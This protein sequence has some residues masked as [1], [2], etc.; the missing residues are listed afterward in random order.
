MRFVIPKG[1]LLCS[2]QYQPSQFDVAILCIP[3]PIIWTIQFSPHNRIGMTA[4]F[5]ATCTVTVILS[6]APTLIIK[7]TESRYHI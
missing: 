3:I 5:L 1:L 7:R 6:Y 2:G 4:L